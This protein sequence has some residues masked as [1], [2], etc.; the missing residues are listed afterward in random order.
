MYLVD[1]PSE[2]EI[3]AVRNA[4]GVTADAM[5][6]K[7]EKVFGICERGGADRRDVGAPDPD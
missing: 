5:I 3:V 2:A 4:L 1:A 7:G 6:R